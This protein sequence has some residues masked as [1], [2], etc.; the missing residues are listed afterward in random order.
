MIIRA[1]S[2]QIFGDIYYIDD[3]HAYR[4]FGMKNPSFNKFSGLILDVKEEKPFA[5]NYFYNILD[6]LINSNIVIC[7][8]PP[9]DSTKE[10][11][12]IISLAS[13]LAQSNARIDG[14]RCL[15]RYKTI[16]KLS[17]GGHRDADVHLN[18][19]TLINSRLI[20]RKE[21]LLIDDVTTSGTSLETCKDILISN[22]AKNVAMLALGHTV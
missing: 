21:I 19:I 16:D 17:T 5:I 12:G 1:D 6:P 9:H 18:S 4:I 10:T 20:N 3:Y 11:S 22:G 7:T 15:I 14:S 13:K 8:V 2:F